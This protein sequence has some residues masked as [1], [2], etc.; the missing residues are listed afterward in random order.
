MTSNECT[1]QALGGYGPYAIFPVR[2]PIFLY[3]GLHTCPRSIETLR[4][5]LRSLYYL[6]L[7]LR[8]PP[9]LRHTTP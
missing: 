8:T 9:I 4:L 2:Q 6:S 1:V 3:S 7:A 5:K